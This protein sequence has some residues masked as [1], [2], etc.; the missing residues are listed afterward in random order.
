MSLKVI[1]R[2]VPTKTIIYGKHA[3]A[4]LDAISTSFP[5]PLGKESWKSM[6]T[7]P[8]VINIGKKVLTL[9]LTREDVSGRSTGTNLI[10]LTRPPLNLEEAISRS[11][12]F[13]DI[14]ISIFSN[15]DE[16][17]L[18]KLLPGESGLE[19][20]VY[21]YEKLKKTPI[22]P[23]IVRRTDDYVSKRG[24]IKS[25]PDIGPCL[26]ITDFTLTDQLIPKNIDKFYISGGGE[27]EDIETIF[28]LS[29]SL[30][31]TRNKYPRYIEIKN[32]ITV[33]ES[34]VPVTI[35]LVEY[36]AFAELFE[37]TRENMEKLRTAST[38]I[39]PIAGD[40]LGVREKDF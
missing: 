19:G 36:E 16:R 39:I 9:D 30:N 8:S 34:N 35:D 28:D 37:K 4:Y 15:A 2:L 24:K 40:K 26:I 13:R 32:F 18:V 6:E 33:L 1:P 3:K 5:K 12:K 21:I 7:D 31:Y 11:P 23:T 22:K 20:F 25:I 29:K 27:K 14:I 38:Q 17:I 10:S